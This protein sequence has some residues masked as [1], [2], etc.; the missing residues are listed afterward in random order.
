MLLSPTFRQPASVT[1]KNENTV[2]VHF[3][4]IVDSKFKY[5]RKEANV[6]VLFGDVRLG[7][8]DKPIHKLNFVR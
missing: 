3:H 6:Y 4:V 2:V 5:D 7:G 8:W 1:S